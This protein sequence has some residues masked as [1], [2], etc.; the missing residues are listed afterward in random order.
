MSRED[1]ELLTVAE[2]IDVCTHQGKYYKLY[3]DQKMEV[4]PFPPDEDQ[5]G[6]YFPMPAHVYRLDDFFII[7]HNG[8]YGRRFYT[9][10]T[11]PFTVLWQD[12]LASY[13]RK[14]KKENRIVLIMAIILYLVIPLVFVYSGI[15]QHVP[16]IKDYVLNSLLRLDTLLAILLRFLIKWAY[17]G[18]FL[19]LV[20]L[21]VVLLYKY[22][23]EDVLGMHK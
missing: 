1:F 9:T 2:K 10:S 21:P 19:M 20:S 7:E 17:I 4:S 5:P 8:Y 11:D 23:K 18:V 3:T 12:K 13:K 15:R 16:S 22:I 14:Y 6:P